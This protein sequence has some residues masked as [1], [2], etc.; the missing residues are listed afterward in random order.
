MTNLV[1]FGLPLLL[2]YSRGEYN[3]AINACADFLKECI[4]NARINEFTEESLRE[5]SR[6]FLESAKW[7][8]FY[9]QFKATDR[10]EWLNIVKSIPLLTSQELTGSEI[11]N[12]DRRDPECTYR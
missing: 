1:A 3:R 11:E 7:I 10:A 4:S 6:F 12:A 5:T 2:T 8:A 9:E